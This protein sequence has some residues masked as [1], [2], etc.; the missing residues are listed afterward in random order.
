MVLQTLRALDPFGNDTTLRG[1][2]SG[3]ASD[4]V[5]VDDAKRVGQLILDSMVGRTCAR[6]PFGVKCKLLPSEHSRP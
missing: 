1:L 5:N 3:V 6:T 4:K 2:V